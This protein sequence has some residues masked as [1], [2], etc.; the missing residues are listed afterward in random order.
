[1]ILKE[2]T[3]KTERTTKRTLKDLNGGFKTKEKSGGITMTFTLDDGEQLRDELEVAKEANQK[4]IEALDDLMDPDQAGWLKDPTQATEGYK[5]AGK[6]DKP[7][8]RQ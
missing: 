5:T 4:A 6:T 2:L 7:Y 3:V 8:R 1:M